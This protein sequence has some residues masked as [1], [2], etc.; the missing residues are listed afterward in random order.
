MLAEG[1]RNYAVVQM[2][3]ARSQL[4]AARQA[5]LEVA[6]LAGGVALV[7][8]TSLRLGV[9]EFELGEA[10]AAADFRLAHRLAPDRAVTDDEFKPAVVTAFRAAIAAPTAKRP[11]NVKVT[12]ANA[13][14][15]I[16]G[17]ARQSGASVDLQIGL[18]LLVVRSPGMIAAGNLATV[19]SAG[20][21]E[22]GAELA[23]EPAMLGLSAGNVE[24][25]TSDTVATSILES[26]WVF[27]ELDAIVIAASVWKGDAMFLVGQRC[28]GSPLRCSPVVE[29]PLSSERGL[30]VAASELIDRLSKAPLRERGATLPASKVVALSKKPIPIDR[31]LKP[32]PWWKNH[33]V[34]IGVG[35]AA[36]AAGTTAAVLSID[37]DSPLVI[38]TDPCEFGSC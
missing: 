29:V 11:V 35:V 28:F 20:P 18:H 4:V 19:P 38:T 9:I 37:K 6:D 22:I 23:P 21:A 34:W 16:D 5:A 2:A 14:V 1:W 27:S 32:R 31:T 25:H 12:P 8:E 17:T 3:S 30:A 7:A 13:T 24:V 10:S 33:W 15:E 36:V 26:A